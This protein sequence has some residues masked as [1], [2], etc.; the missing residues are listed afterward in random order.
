MRNVGE[1]GALH[2]ASTLIALFL[3]Q[4]YFITYWMSVSLHASTH[5]YIKAKHAY[6]EIDFRDVYKRNSYLSMFPV[7][8]FKARKHILINCP[9]HNIILYPTLNDGLHNSCILEEY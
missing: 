3:Y 5:I 8:I 1:I 4:L 7:S 6:Y 2:N 9:I